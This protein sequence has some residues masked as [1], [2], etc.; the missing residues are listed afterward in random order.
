MP[1][2]SS[3]A[4]L[5]DI[6]HTLNAFYIVR[7]KQETQPNYSSKLLQIIYCDFQSSPSSDKLTESAGSMT[8]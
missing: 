1:L 3:C 4:E 8:I 5:N 7:E 6:G 2:P